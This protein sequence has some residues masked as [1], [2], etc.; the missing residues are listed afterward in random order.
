MNAFEEI[1]D[2]C[3]NNCRFCQKDKIYNCAKELAQLEDDINMV[4]SIYFDLLTTSIICRKCFTE[5]YSDYYSDD[6]A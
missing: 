3:V 6:G 1:E 2:G 4:D 5:E